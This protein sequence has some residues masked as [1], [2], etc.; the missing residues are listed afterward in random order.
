MELILNKADSFGFQLSDSHHPVQTFFIFN[1]LY[2]D[3]FGIQFSPSVVL[4][5]ILSELTELNQK[6]HTVSLQCESLQTFLQYSDN[7]S[8]LELGM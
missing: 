2:K 3:P 4:I 1:S 7:L 5:Q 8:R 6:L